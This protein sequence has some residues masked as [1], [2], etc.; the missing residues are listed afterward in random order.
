MELQHA[1]KTPV[2]AGWSG[3]G[4][5]RRQALPRT[6]G[7]GNQ[8]HF[9]VPDLMRPRSCFRSTSFPPGHKVLSEDIPLTSQPR[10][11]RMAA[12]P[13]LASLPHVPLVQLLP[14]GPGAAFSPPGAGEVSQ[15]Q[16]VQGRGCSYDEVCSGFK[17]PE[18]LHP[19]AP[20]RQPE[21]RLASCKAWSCTVPADSKRMVKK[22]PNSHTEK[23]VGSL[24]LL[25][26][27]CQTRQESRGKASVRPGRQGGRPVSV[28]RV[29][30]EQ[31]QQPPA[32]PPRACSSARPALASRLQ[33]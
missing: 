7:L 25:D 26:A 12:G 14:R 18:G 1:E 2:G 16:T 17:K 8:P 23:L 3:E 32:S 21:P 24:S 5:W 27:R 9:W 19:P 22:K 31:P 15:L 6:P 33:S 28:N 10:P 29:V 11:L 20:L 4:G 13:L 30:A